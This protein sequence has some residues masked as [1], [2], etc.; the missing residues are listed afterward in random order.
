MLALRIIGMGTQDSDEARKR[1]AE[2]RAWVRSTFSP[3]ERHLLEEAE[4]PDGGNAERR[5]ELAARFERRMDAQCDEHMLPPR[6]FAL[7]DDAD[8]PRRERPR[9]ELIALMIELDACCSALEAAGRDPITERQFVALYE[10]LVV[11]RETCFARS[12]DRA[13]AS[14]VT[15]DE[16]DAELTA[17]R[18]R[19]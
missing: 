11:E 18:G 16:V 17:I 1:R 15:R 10:R 3:D 2:I 13:A 5:D 4:W 7:D 9:S 19:S 12:R 8:A 14:A 6:L